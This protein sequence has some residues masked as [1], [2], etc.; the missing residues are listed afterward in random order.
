M[1]SVPSSLSEGESVG[2]GDT[3]DDMEIW[4][5][6]GVGVGGLLLACVA[7]AIVGAVILICCRRGNGPYRYLSDDL[8][9]GSQ[10]EHTYSMVYPLG[11]DGAE[12]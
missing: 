3:D 2:G 1:V 7:A 10:A 4:Y 12:F 8:I 6:V 11:D 5:I 9:G